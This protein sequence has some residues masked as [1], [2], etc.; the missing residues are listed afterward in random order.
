[1]NFAC[2]LGYQKF[3]FFDLF[4]QFHILPSSA[5][6]RFIKAIKDFF[7][8]VF[9]RLDLFLSWSLFIMSNA[10]LLIF[11]AIQVYKSRYHNLLA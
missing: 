6:F 9:R 1:M 2:F 3:L 5:W 8:S 10:S 11:S 7:N 4:L